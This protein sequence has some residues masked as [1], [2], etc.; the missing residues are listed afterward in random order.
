MFESVGVVKET[1]KFETYNDFYIR[2]HIIRKEF[3]G[4]TAKDKEIYKYYLYAN[5]ILS[6]VKK[7]II[8]SYLVEPKDS[9]FYVFDRDL[10]R[11]YNIGKDKRLD[12]NGNRD[13]REH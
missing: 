10:E 12:K 2:R 6:D 9:P 13:R 1:L 4:L 7:D 3:A 8:W 11:Y 5:S